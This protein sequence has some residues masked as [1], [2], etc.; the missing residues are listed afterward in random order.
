VE[1]DGLKSIKF[2]TTRF[3][4]KGNKSTCAQ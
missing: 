1:T 4:V 3:K 2:T